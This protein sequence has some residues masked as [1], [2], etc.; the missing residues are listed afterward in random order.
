MS[1]SVSQASDL[2]TVARFNTLYNDHLDR[3]QKDIYRQRMKEELDK[4]REECTFQP[5]TNVRMD[6]SLTPELT[7]VS[8]RN[9]AWIAHRDAKI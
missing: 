8:E 6:R 7:A 2:Q 1:K 5:K 3:Q 9:Q 4:A